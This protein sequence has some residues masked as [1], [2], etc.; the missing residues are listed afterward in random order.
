MRPEY[1]ALIAASTAA[2]LDPTLAFG[3]VIPTLNERDNVEPMLARLA[4]ALVGIRW[5]AVFVDDGSTDGT[6]D[7]LRRIACQ[8]P[9][10]RLVQRLGRSGL[11][12]A[13]VEGMMATA[14]PV[15]GVIDGDMQHD[16]AILPELWR[17]VTS[18]EADVAIGSRYVDGG[19]TGGWSASRL[20]A[21]R[22]A[23]WLGNRV[24]GT[25]STDPMSGF[26]VI[27]RDLIV[28][29][30]PRLSG[31][32]FKLLIDL[33]ASSQRPLLVRE[34]PY[35]FRSR[36]AGDSKMGSAV[37]IEYL[38][39]LL[40]KTAGRILPTRLLLFLMVGGTGLAVHLAILAGSL[41][42][43]ASF[44]VGQSVAVAAAILFNF[45]LNNLLTYRDRQL[46][47]WR[48]FLGLASFAGVCSVGAVANV[49]VASF[50]F[51]EGRLWWQAG[52]AGAA[53]SALWNYAASSYVTWRK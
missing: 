44:P 17:L 22:M 30:Q 27:R 21:S 9:H 8:T 4:V 14:A 3:L 10:V 35:V 46:K 41:R 23:T 12:T 33:L 25:A 48:F 45:T 40:D 36:I 51:A 13:I 39:L 49:G 28:E 26:F 52:I 1:S 24:I 2:E 50:A 29:L 38:T 37:A 42:V 53:I 7:L 5:E 11:S 18:Q 20:R 6:L 32:G 19:G 43:G 31:I 34:V 16:E 15:V 47:G